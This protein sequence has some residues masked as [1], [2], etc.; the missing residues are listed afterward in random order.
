[1]APTV[2]GEWTPRGYGDIDPTEP[3]ACRPVDAGVVA[4]H[5]PWSTLL[6]AAHTFLGVVGVL[7]LVGGLL[8]AG[9]DLSERGEFLDGLFAFFGGIAAV[10]GAIAATIGWAL[11]RGTRAGRRR[12]DAG[13]PSQLRGIAT[14]GVSCGGLLIAA[15][16][17]MWVAALADGSGGGLAGLITLLPVGGYT[18]VAA[19]TLRAAR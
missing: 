5:R 15:Y 8:L 11:T 2:S 12:A 7:L 1:M 18:A 17:C 13:D 14:V 9:A 6:L 4:R 16:L 19:A 10:A 3:Y